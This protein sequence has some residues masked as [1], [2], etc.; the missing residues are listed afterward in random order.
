MTEKV[1]PALPY[2]WMAEFDS[3]EALVAAA[4]KAHEAGYR[5][6]DGFSPFPVEGL[7]EALGEHK[8]WLP[9]LV[10]MGGIGGAVA[11]FGMQYYAN[12][13]SYPLN[14]GGRPLNSWPAFIPVTFELTILA[15]AG[16]AVLGMLALNGLP[17]PYHPLFAVPRFELASRQGFFLCIESLDPKFESAK[18][19]TFLESLN[20]IG[21]YE[22][23][24]W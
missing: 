6:M 23:P 8:N 21:V 15:A 2:G 18:T 5:K 4:E 24:A 16:I 1:T 14:I 19:K 9:F 22:V 3:A 7:N 20:P 17:Q 12:V 10:L 13:I 11:G